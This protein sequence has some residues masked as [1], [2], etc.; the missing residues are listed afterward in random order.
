[1]P[2][3]VAVAVAVA[4]ATHQGGPMLAAAW[5]IAYVSPTYESVPTWPD[6]AGRPGGCTHTSLHQPVAAAA[7]SARKAP[8]WPGMYGRRPGR[9]VI[10]APPV[11]SKTLTRR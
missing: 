11:I 4:P 5:R 6:R 3:S 9:S 8:A 2:R 10:G 7:G 1:M